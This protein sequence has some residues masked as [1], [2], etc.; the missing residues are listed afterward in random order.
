MAPAEV[1]VT[2]LRREKMPQNEELNR[3]MLID[4]L[5][6]IEERR[7]HVAESYYN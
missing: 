5:D 2:S 1:N 7:D 6:A 4:A 3:E